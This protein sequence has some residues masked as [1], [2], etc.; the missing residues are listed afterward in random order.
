MRISNNTFLLVLVLLSNFILYIFFFVFARTHAVPETESPL[1]REIPEII[2]NPNDNSIKIGIFVTRI[3]NLDFTTEKF[4][5][6]FWI[7]A[8][9]NPR[10]LD[11]LPAIQ[12]T[13]DKKYVFFENIEVVNAIDSNISDN[14][15]KE[16][17]QNGIEYKYEMAKFGATLAMPWDVRC[18]PF[19]KQNLKIILESVGIDSGSIKF[20][21]DNVNSIISDDLEMSD[22]K[23][24]PVQLD[25]MDYTYQSTF[26]DPSGIKGVYPRLVFSIPLTRIGSRIFLTAYLGFFIAYII[27]VVLM[28]LDREMLG[29]RLGL[30]MTSLFAAIGN[31]YTIDN[32]FPRQTYFSLSDLIQVIT[33]II[34]AL[35]L[36]DVISMI[37][38]VKTEK[39]EL[40]ARIEKIFFWIIVPAYPAIILIGV[41]A[42]K[43]IK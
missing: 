4:S 34:I 15:A 33:F 23:I 6:I 18:Y 26:G 17:T 43:L 12:E 10:V 1:S 30:V 36:L 27:V 14:Y 5:A 13:E 37:R 11:S 21:P 39:K 29:E 2:L 41:L 25:C 3:Y 24:D 8:I 42:A 16:F 32:Y 38:L 40:A 20:S 28:L 22:W 19:D 7:W 35:G 31:K 9:Y